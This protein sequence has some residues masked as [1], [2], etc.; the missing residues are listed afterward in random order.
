MEVF[1][2]VIGLLEQHD[3]GPLRAG[4]LSALA[5]R[6]HVPGAQLAV[7]QDG[8]TFA[9][10]VG[11]LEFGTRRRVGRECAFPIGSIT[12]SFT[13]TLAMML[14]ADGD[15][16]LDAPVGDY[17]PELDDL[18]ARLTLRQLLSHTGGLAAGP[19]SDEVFAA[20][21][22]RYV[23]DHCHRRNLV[24]A[25]GIGFSYSN[26]G[27]V[28]AGWLIETVTGM[29]WWEA[30]ES[31]LL[32]PLGIEPTFVS[33][34]PAGPGGPTGRPIATGHSVNAGRTR[35]VRPVE[36]PAEAA[37]GA[38]AASAVDLVSLARLHLGRGVP[39][40]LPKAYADRMRQPAPGAD[41]FGLADGW[42]LGLALFRHGGVE[43]VGH[44][45][46]VD[47]ASCYLRIDPAG[48]RVIAFTSNA[49]TGAGM[50]RD[51]VA[52]LARV[53]IPVAPAAVAPPGPVVAPPR[54]CAGTYANGDMEFVVVKEG[55]RH[56]LGVDGEFGALT[57]HEDL[58]FSLRD[59]NSGRTV[60]GGR[61][62]RDQATGA[63]DG[64]Q[65][66][67]RVATRR[68]HIHREVGRRL[69]A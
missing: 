9:V 27:Y 35:P 22:R 44:D 51:V 63:L 17:L 5:R 7:H 31:I 23:T 47:G 11:E 48:G 20:T 32:R 21:A 60:V 52:E 6:H 50:W 58:V 25:P 30:V 12:K 39:G 18:G 68:T 14:V 19:D 3:V 26:L 36:A 29:S 37:T 8:E 16:D 54:G 67:G 53:G 15:V 4:F 66:N 61:F 59:P 49:N 13:A 69:V 43:W 65:V 38:L 56:Y 46:N 64:V 45:G 41:P 34:D 62:L 24:L 42:G 55:G 10:E 33:A 57:F 40:L 1:R 28:I 2:P